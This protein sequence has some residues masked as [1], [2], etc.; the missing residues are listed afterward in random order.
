[1]G[2]NDKEHVLKNFVPALLIHFLALP[3]GAQSFPPQLKETGFP[4]GAVVIQVENI[5]NYPEGESPVPELP[6]SF[7]RATVLKNGIL[8]V[9]SRDGSFEQSLSPRNLTEINQLSSD[10]YSVEIDEKVNQPDY[11]KTATRGV[12]AVA[13]YDWRTKEWSNDARIIWTEDGCDYKTTLEPRDL[14]DRMR[15]EVL[16]ARV[17]AIAFE[18]VKNVQI[19]VSDSSFSDRKRL[20]VRRRAD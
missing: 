13:H 3:V 20:L 15:A 7:R 6:G 17:E 14:Y 18:F 12:M 5:L 4:K 11:I 10:L 9:E 8:V 19:H 2:S 1:M 16:R